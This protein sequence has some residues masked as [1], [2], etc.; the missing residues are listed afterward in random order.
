MSKPPRRWKVLAVAGA[1]LVTVA[2]AGAA[3]TDGGHAGAT[4][5]AAPGDPAGSPIALP[6]GATSGGPAALVDPEAGTGIGA[7]APGNVSEYPGASVPLGMVQF[8]PDTSPDRQVT[9]GSGY[10]YADA[11]ISGFSLTHLSGPGC[12][13]YGDIPILP[14]S[15]PIPADPDTAVQPFSHANEQSSAGNYAVRLGPASGGQDIGV[16]LTATTRSALGAFTF[17]ASPPAAGAATTGGDGLLFK[18]SDS[19]NGST[20]SRVQVVGNNELVGSVTSG[21][22]CGIP[23]NYTLHFDAQFSRPFATSGTWQ[24]G[25]VGPG[26]SCAGTSTTSCGAW[27][28]FLQSAQP[29]SQTILAK[30]G[31]S[32]VSAAGA[33]GNLAAE[34]PGWNFQKVSHAATAEWN[35]LLGRMAVQG[36][37]RTAQRTFYTALY[38]SLLFPSV[39]SDDDGQYI[40]FDHRVHTLA[41]GHVQYANFSECDIYRSEV[42]LLATLLP[43]PTSQMVQSMLNDA[44][45]TKGGFLPR[46]GIADNDAGQW[47]G[48]SADPIIADA[49]A[50]GARQFNVGEALK[51]MV[52]G[53]TVPESGFVTER[54]NLEEYEAHGWVPALTYDATSYPYTDGGSETLEYSVDDFSISQLA[55]AVGDNTE[56]GLFAKRGQNWQNLFN[57]ATGYLAARQADGSF[58]SG[59]A[60]QPASPADQAQ[61]VA[62][63]GFEEGNA[64]QYTWAV[65]Q[66]LAGL[67]GLMGGDRAAV[68]ELDGFFTS[69]NAT[70][71][72]PYD[73]AGNEPDEWAPFEYDYAGDPS[74]TQA[75]VRRIMTQL[76]SLAPA[77]EPGED[78]LGA[79]SSW[80]VW[81]ALGLYPETPGVANLAMTSPLF[82][83]VDITLGNGRTLAISGSHAPDGYIEGARL[84]IGSGGSSTWDKPWLPASALSEGADLSVDLGNAPDKAWGS[85]PSAAPPSFSHGAA[86]AVAFTT[87]GG[88]LTVATGGSATFLL[89]VQEASGGSGS[90]RTVMWH[91]VPSAGTTISPASGSLRVVDGRST[92]PLVVT[93]A[94][95]GTSTVTFDLAQRGEPLPSLT[96]DVN[97]TAS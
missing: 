48:D 92:A 70:R 76:Y 89:G 67:F 13:I 5:T 8:S 30:V 69:L 80:Y 84:A 55:G 43:G 2:G 12:A 79:L 7:A 1:V 3:A 71:F 24:N 90:P 61:G 72:A 38:H 42:P 74:G 26:G 88:S 39:F 17:P 40:G 54:Q 73:W 16:Q 46:W 37:T 10:D 9:T 15:G 82:P 60:F 32:F 44:A 14:V 64:I 22:F 19:A 95:P 47:D 29:A 56:A 21:D 96:L 31:I 62:Q 78:D 34:N 35:G 93:S 66:N 57:P 68:T 45:Q 20:A 81:A 50:Y 52:H 41:S 51:D 65:P 23:G 27:V 91:A 59:P 97:A 94:S 36:G 49:Y 63:Q 85:A 87:P 33:A 58:P 77:S 25:S 86:P 75:V 83:R 4:P 6:L 11:N 53:A 28:S 18:V